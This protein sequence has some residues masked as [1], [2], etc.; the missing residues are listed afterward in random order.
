VLGLQ[1]P[2][3]AG[4]PLLYRPAWP[5]AAAAVIACVIVTAVLGVLLAGHPEP[6]R[7]D[8][9][10]DGHLEARFGDHSLLAHSAYLGDPY[11]VAGIC[12]AAVL[13]CVLGRR[14]RAA[15]L[16]LIAVPAAIVLT[17]SILKPLI[18]RTFYGNLTYPS[19]HTTAVATMAVAA[20][21]V[22]TGPARPP[23]PAAVRWLLSAAVLAVI[24]VVAAGLVVI[25]YHY[26]TDT[27]G[28]AGVGTAVALA[29]A[30]GLDAAAAG[31][32][33]RRAPARR[34]P[35]GRS[36]ISAGARELPRP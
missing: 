26:F 8:R 31:L 3:T 20:A 9:W 4:R 15:L 13:A 23:L 2:R 36:G 16:V 17:D 28:G 12:T 27:I 22:L 21:V 10:I 1:R 35:A 33:A 29:T 32:A 14:L 5:T 7:V 25:H 19:G 24:P 34:E 11:W 18:D 6:G 30:L